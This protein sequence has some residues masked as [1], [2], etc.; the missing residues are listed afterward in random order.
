[1]AATRSRDSSRAFH[2]VLGLERDLAPGVNAR[3]EGYYKRLSDLIVGRLE[4]EAER[5]ARVAQHDFPAELSS[6]I[7]AAAQI[8]SVPTNDGQGRSYG[9]DVFLSRRATSPATRLSGWIGYTWGRATRD[10]YG[11][12]Y[13]FDYDRRHA[14][15]VVGAWRFGPKL[16]VAATGKLYSGFPLTP[17]LGLRVSAV[18]LQEGGATRLVPER[19]PL[20]GLVWTTDLG[21][22]SN[23][24]RAR[25]PLFTR[26]DL[27]VNWKPGGDTG[28]WLF[29]LDII[30]LL[31]RQNVGAYEASLEYDPAS[32]RP[33]LVEKPAQR[34]PFLPSFGIRFRF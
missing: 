7:P 22:V 30:N 4:T 32:D 8:T 24:N 29:Y 14:L 16:E 31:N 19:D 27:R 21:D 1:M 25:L 12:S 20:G 18:E 23:L 34:I 33:R 3:V 5:L 17:V 2:A 6:S 28:R 15:N 13:P 10:A 9:V 26:V 11:Q